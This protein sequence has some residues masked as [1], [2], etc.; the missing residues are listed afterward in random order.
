MGTS[1]YSPFPS[2][3]HKSAKKAA[4]RHFAILLMAL[5]VLAYVE[6][7]S[8]SRITRYLQLD[9]SDRREKARRYVLEIG[10]VHLW[11]LRARAGVSDQSSRTG[12]PGDKM[13]Q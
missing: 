11:L 1:R 4:T 9:C 6:A 12:R 10:P 13:H 7:H 2:L 5:C 8:L 3:I